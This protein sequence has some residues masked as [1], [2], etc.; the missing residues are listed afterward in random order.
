[1]AYVQSVPVVPRHIRPVLS[2][3]YTL[4]VVIRCMR[5]GL[6]G[7]G[8]RSSVFTATVP[9]SQRSL[10]QAGVST[11]RRSAAGNAVVSAE[12]PEGPETERRR[13]V[14][15]GATAAN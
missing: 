1:M 15:G 9:R 7:R 10:Q 4:L 8:S 12:Q 3:P 2:L 5:A 11:E 13:T 6:A 14:C